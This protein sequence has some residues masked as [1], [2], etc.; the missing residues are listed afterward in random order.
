MYIR[1]ISSVVTIPSGHL[2]LF[3]QQAGGLYSR[4]VLAAAAASLELRVRARAAEPGY[5]VNFPVAL[6]Q[7]HDTF[8]GAAFPIFGHLDQV[9][10]GQGAVALPAPPGM[11][12]ALLDRQHQPAQAELILHTTL[13]QVAGGQV[14]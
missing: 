9:A 3:P 14:G 11:A 8:Q 12:G 10:R 5:F 4:T 2:F 13:F 7:V 6:D 1:A